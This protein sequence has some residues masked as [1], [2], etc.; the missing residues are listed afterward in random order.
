MK[1]LRLIPI[2]FVV[3]VAEAQPSRTEFVAGDGFVRS[4]FGITVEFAVDAT[5]LDPNEPEGSLIAAFFS[6]PQHLFMTFESTALTSV[7]IDR[8][9]ALVTGTATVTDDRSGFEGE[10]EFS[11][12]FQDFR[13]R[14]QHDTLTL[15][16]H[17]PS[18][19]ETFAGGMVPGDIQ[20][21]TR[22]R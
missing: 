8:R 13:N 12:V 7:A 16:L 18:G 6:F 4:S 21:G 5:Q 11:A 1:Y 14:P 22:R 19:P 3:S 2:L 20:V 9:T 10:V 17:F 15:T